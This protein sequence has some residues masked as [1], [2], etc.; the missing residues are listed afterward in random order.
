[1]N[2]THDKPGRRSHLRFE[3]LG[4]LKVYGRSGE[5]TPSAPK[6]GLLLATLLVNRDLVVSNSQL[7]REIWSERPPRRASAA[8]HVYV[9]QLRKLLVEAG[10]QAERILTRAPGY[11]LEIGDARLDI[12]DFQMLAGR[13]RAHLEAGRF[14]DALRDLEAAL[15]LYRGPVLDGIGE[16]PVMAGLAAWVEEER[17]NCL[18]WSID[19][20]LALG[21]HQEVTSQ[22]S[23]LTT[24]YPLREAFFQQLMLAL[25]RSERQ[26]EALQVYQQARRAL[27][28]DL[29]LEPSAPLRRLQQAILTSGRG[30]QLSAAI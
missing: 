3:V 23:S 18:E 1:V 22:L 8:L 4:S 17:L 7:M 21:R 30:F 29:G 2:L 11:Q 15:A 5:F 26:A 13:G 19:A 24:R 14:E 28:T 16:G 25:Y 27:R 9:S 10:D 12:A 20:H 6:I